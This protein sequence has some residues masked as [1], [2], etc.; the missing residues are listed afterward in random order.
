MH[1]E[2]KNRRIQQ[3]KTLEEI[4]N[5]I[6]VK[7]S[8]LQAIEEGRFE[9]LPEPVYTKSYIK[10]YSIYLKVDPSLIL[11]EYEQYL[12]SKLS[13]KKPEKDEVAKIQEI[14]PPKKKQFKLP[15]TKNLPITKNLPSWAVKFG[16]ILLVIVVVALLLNIGK[17]DEQIPPPPPIVIKEE[18]NQSS[19]LAEKTETALEPKKEEQKPAEEPQA[20]EQTLKIEATDLV[21]MRITI[22]NK[23][24][25]EIMLNPGDK[26]NLKA[27]KTFKLHIGNAG[28]VKVIF[29]DKDLGP[30]GEKGQ[31][32]YLDLPK[33]TE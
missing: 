19:N 16:I 5:Y 26:I 33:K 14:E 1:E 24:R 27:N 4:A 9:E 11:K 21:W 3:E 13:S 2:L 25:K 15:V 7:K 28:G 29:N 23:E 32:V 17:R 6:K 31:V 20:Q 18:P 10:T 12:E 22:D 8:Y 30:L